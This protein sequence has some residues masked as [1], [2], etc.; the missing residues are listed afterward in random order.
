MD[1]IIL[2][3]SS[4][5]GNF[6]DIFSSLS[7]NFTKSFWV[8]R[9]SHIRIILE[10]DHSVHIPVMFI[11]SKTRELFNKSLNNRSS[12]SHPLT[13]LMVTYLRLFSK[14]NLGHTTFSFSSSLISW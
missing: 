11:H 4:T 3:D 10:F 5:P 6:L 7:P 9:D 8:L 1:Y 2:K 12:I 13:L 14:H